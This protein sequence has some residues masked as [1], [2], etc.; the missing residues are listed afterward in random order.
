[1]Q[2]DPIGEVRGLYEWLGTPVTEEFERRM[3]RWWEANA[4]NREP[5]SHSELSDYGLRPDTVRATFA[6]YVG[7]VQEWTS[8]RS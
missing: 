6:D 3:R 1:M 8:H 7:R 2:A 4:E 5:S